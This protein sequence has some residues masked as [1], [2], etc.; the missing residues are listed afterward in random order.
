MKRMSIINVC[1]VLMRF[2]KLKVCKAVWKDLD[3][4]VLMFNNFYEYARESQCW[5]L[6]QAGSLILPANRKQKRYE[7]FIISTTIWAIVN[8]KNHFQVI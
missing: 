1:K 2:W 4:L 8:P 5:T 6:I 3:M 7:Q